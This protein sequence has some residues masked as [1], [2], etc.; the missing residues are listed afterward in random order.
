MIDALIPQGNDAS[1]VFGVVEWLLHNFAKSYRRCSNCD[2]RDND[3]DPTQ[4]MSQVASR[5]VSGAAIRSG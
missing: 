3:T 4:I 2:E 1:I 5:E